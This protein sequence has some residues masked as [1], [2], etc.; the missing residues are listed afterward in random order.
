M[1]SIGHG[2]LVP[3][4]VE[5]KLYGRASYCMLGQFGNV[6]IEQVLRKKQ[7]KSP[8]EP[9]FFACSFLCYWAGLQPEETQKLI[10]SGV[11]LMV[12]TTIKLLRKKNEDHPWLAL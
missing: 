12:R 9:L 3:C 7:T 4:P 1:I 10:N 8:S 5:K 2:C 11:D 6:E